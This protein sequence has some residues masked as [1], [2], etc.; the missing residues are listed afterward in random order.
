[1]DNVEVL[2][3]DASLERVV[4]RCAS[5]CTLYDAGRFAHSVTVEPD[6][7][8]LPTLDA[9]IGDR[10]R[11]KSPGR[12]DKKKQPAGRYSE[13][14]SHAAPMRARATKTAVGVKVS[15]HEVAT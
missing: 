13:S 2:C 5:T 1:M 9:G 10:A 4:S 6:R 3:A 11:S 14:K 15:S 12:G 7:M 8:N